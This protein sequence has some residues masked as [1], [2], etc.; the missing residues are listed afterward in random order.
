MSLAGSEAPGLDVI[1]QALADP[2]R[3]GMVER[4]SLGRASVKELAKPIGIALPSVLKHLKVLEAGGIVTS[5]KRGRVR[6]YE[7]RPT[8][9]NAIDE[10]TA[11]RKRNWA[12]AFD[13]LAEAMTEHPEQTEKKAP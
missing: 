2:H 13:R 7:L 10:W 3:R 1:F 12:R 8:A 11:A 5:E 6:T 4:L 9:L